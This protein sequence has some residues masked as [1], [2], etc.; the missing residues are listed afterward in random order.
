MM[1]KTK[2]A[3][4]LSRGDQIT[5]GLNVYTVGNIENYWAGV[6][7]VNLTDIDGWTTNRYIQSNDQITIWKGGK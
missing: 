6:T 2:S 7:R 5:I 3:K 4:S 1:T